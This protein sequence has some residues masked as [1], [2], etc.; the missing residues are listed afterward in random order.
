MRI[1]FML[2][3]TKQAKCRQT[4]DGTRNFNHPLLMVNAVDSISFLLRSRDTPSSI[5]WL[6]RT[7]SAFAVTLAVLL[8]AITAYNFNGRL[9]GFIVGIFLLSNPEFFSSAHILRRMPV[10]YLAY[11]YLSCALPIIQ[12]NKVFYR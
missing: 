1:R 7:W 12:K 6:G 3:S 8:T 10:F 11:L 2:D 4:L 9:A 5:L